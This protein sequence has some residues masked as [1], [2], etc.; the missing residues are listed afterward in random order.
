M[1]RRRGADGKVDTVDE[2]GSGSG[3]SR[4]S[5]DGKG[6]ETTEDEMDEDAVL[7]KRPPVT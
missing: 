4:T 3:H 1:R 7:L 6:G 2:G 5:E